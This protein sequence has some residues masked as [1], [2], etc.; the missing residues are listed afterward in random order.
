[1]VDAI[2]SRNAYIKA[3][4]SKLPEVERGEQRTI[5]RG[6]CL[7]NI[8]KA[9]VKK[10]G[11]TSNAAIS[12]YML[13]IAKLN[14]LDTS[15]K[16]NG[17]KINS[18]IYLPGQVKAADTVEKTDS[19]NVPKQQPAKALNDAEQS[20]ANLAQNVMSNDNVYAKQSNTKLLS[21]TKIYHV[22]EKT[23]INDAPLGKKLLLSFDVGADGKI[24]EISFEDSKNI[25]IYGYDY[26][27]N[28]KGQITSH[29]RPGISKG[30]VDKEQLAAL[31]ERLQS[32]T[33][34]Q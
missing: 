15:E 30:K 12:E 16:M 29:S 31:N 24:E 27:V 9:E 4:M 20:F 23:K 10:Q 7:W 18:T 2:N 21:G 25:N 19:A 13:L 8:A 34:K 28:S 26:D 22:Y 6:D 1:M 3:K 5:K 17:I 32:L 11:K 33:D 14:G